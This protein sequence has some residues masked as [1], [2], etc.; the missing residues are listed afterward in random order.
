MQLSE[1]FSL[2]EFTRSETAQRKGIDNTPDAE[3]IANLAELALALEKVREI[4]RRPIH[5]TSG[6]RSPK[7]NAVIGSS[8]TSAH[9]KGY[10]ADFVVPGMT[11]KEVC[12]AIIDSGIDHDQV[13][14]E[15]NSWCHF[16]IDPRNRKMALTIDKNGT[17]VGIG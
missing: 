8:P 17:R 3:T 5:I 10:A 14:H 16:S 7:V 4:V 1:H 6:Y 2:A 12:Q 9:I 11:P 15:F 13:I